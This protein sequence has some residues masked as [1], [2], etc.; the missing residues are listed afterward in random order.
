M[1]VTEITR[2]DET[3]KIKDEGLDGYV[4]EYEHLGY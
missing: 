2:D 3:F 1:S 4:I